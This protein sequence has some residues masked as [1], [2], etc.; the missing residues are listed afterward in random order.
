MIIINRKQNKIE[1]FMLKLEI[2]EIN[3]SLHTCV[4]I[5]QVFQIVFSI[6]SINRGWG[7]QQQKLKSNSQNK[8]VLWKTIDKDIFFW[9]TI[10]LM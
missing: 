7:H 5:M 4:N 10:F 6:L 3:L 8:H 2:T 1:E 9:L